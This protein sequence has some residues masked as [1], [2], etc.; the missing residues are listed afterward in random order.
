MLFAAICSVDAVV[1]I[2][3]GLGTVGAAGFVILSVANLTLLA[4]EPLAGLTGVPLL[5]AVAGAFL[6]LGVADN[7][8]FVI[9]PAGFLPDTGTDAA[10]FF[11]T[12]VGFC[13][14]ASVLFD[15]LMVRF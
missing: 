11:I 9:M 14:V 6:L 15:G 1:A 3:A 10:V 12:T 2:I 8:V 7:A 5:L 13:A 4:I